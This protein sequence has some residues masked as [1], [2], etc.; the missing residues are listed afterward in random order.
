MN[1]NELSQWVIFAT[2]LLGC[3]SHDEAVAQTGVPTSN[4]A[5]KPTPRKPLYLQRSS[6]AKIAKWQASDFFDKKKLLPLCEAISAGDVQTVR[7]LIDSGVNLNASGKHGLTP[8]YWA[9]IVDNME[10]FKLLLKHGADPD[11]KLQ[12]PIG[13]RWQR[14]FF[15][16]D[17]VMWSSL[18]QT[19][20]DYCLAAL[21]YT[22]DADQVG[23][24]GDNFINLFLIEDLGVTP[25]RMRRF[26]QFGI[27]VNRKDRFG[28]TPCH[29]AL[30]SQTGWDRPNA[31]LELL[32][33]G[34]DPRS[35]HTNGLG[36]VADRVESRLS[37]LKD[38]DKSYD[39]LVAWL[40]EN[41]RKIHIP[42]D[43]Q[44]LDSGK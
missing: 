18:K 26:I 43:P 14:P 32:K 29:Q 25:V 22:A 7:R 24:T 41:Y 4:K 16:G 19:R 3:T 31:C 8:L 42:D 30:V 12:E 9:Y 28:E 27:D 15:R 2:L 17:S 6:I 36:D 44:T 11:Q 38:D 5:D 40:N 10:L 13:P 23:Q 35:R 20:P 37:K 33:A 39:Q 34:A 1:A 21:P